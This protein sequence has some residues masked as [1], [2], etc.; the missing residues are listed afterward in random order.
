MKVK[1]QM[2]LHLMKEVKNNKKFYR[3]I[4]QK[5]QTKESVL[6]LVN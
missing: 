1:A 3:Y 2:E 5:R 4:D 6:S